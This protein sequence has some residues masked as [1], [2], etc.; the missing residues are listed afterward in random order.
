MEGRRAVAMGVRQRD[1]QLDSVEPA[2]ILRRCFLGVRDAA[3]GGHE[4]E[5]AGPREPF[6]AEAVVVDHFAVEQPRDCLQAHVRVRSDVHRLAFRERERAEAVEEPPRTNQT[7][8]ARGQRAA[9]LHSA[10]IR[11][12]RGM[13]SSEGLL[14]AVLLFKHAA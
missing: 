2:C 4:V 14:I 7:A 11:E 5:F 8:R 6:A 3:A 10:E 12:F 9:D 13:E 1:P